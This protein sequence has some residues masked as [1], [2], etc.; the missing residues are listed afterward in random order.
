MRHC[1]SISLVADPP[2]AGSL[3]HLHTY[4]TT[5]MQSGRDA[6]CVKLDAERLMTHAS[7]PRGGVD[8]SLSTI[9]RAHKRSSSIGRNAVRADNATDG[10]LP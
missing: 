8:P 10:Q 3:S 1:I 9:S 4:K 6:S 5:N 2:G 7:V